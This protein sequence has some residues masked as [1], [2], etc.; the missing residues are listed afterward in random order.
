MTQ[1]MLAR[2]RPD[3]LN[4]KAYSSARSLYE[5]D[6]STIFLDANECAFEP[7]IGAQNLSRYPA[8]QPIK[9]MN[10]LCR[11]YDVSSRNLIST[12]GADEAI[13]T[14]IRSICIP[15]ID[16]III[17]P[18]T[19][20]MYEH[21]AT[22]Q[23]IEV[24]KAPLNDDFSI[25]YNAIKNMATGTT[26]IVFLCSPNNPTGSYIPIEQIIELCNAFENKTFIV[27]DETYIEF[28]G[29]E[30]AIRLTEKYNNLIIMRT[31]SKA[32]AAAGIRCGVAISQSYIIDVLKKVIAPYPISQCV[33]NEVTTILSEKNLKRLNT[34]RRDI[35]RIRD[36][37]INQIQKLPVVKK[38][39]PTYANF[40]LVEFD[41]ADKICNLCKNNGIIL[42]NQSHQEKLQN[43][44]RIGIGSESDMNKL[45]QILSGRTISKTIASRRATI[46]RRTNETSI[47][48]TVDLDSTAPIFINTGIG[49]YDHMLEQIA[50]HAGFSL[51]LECDGDLHIDPHHTIEDCAIAFGQCLKEALGNKLG[52]GRYG[53]V[54]PMDESEASCSLDLSNRSYL[55][56]EGNF[57]ATMVGDLPTDMIEH[58]FRSIA[59]NLGASIHLKVYGDNAHHMVE[60]CFKSFA[61]ALGQ[62][63][64]ISSTSLPSSKG[65]L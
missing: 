60:A 63:I 35:I 38:I 36:Q 31:L 10:A 29:L 17:C 61:R 55:K 25:N 33:A 18:P 11:L 24:K 49:F 28:S 45:V 13:D 39:Y 20:P 50:K 41:D 48:V 42:R 56:F 15:S 12:R 16:N 43:C 64:K 65:I 51:S 8:Q 53:F 14:L 54:V 7:Y 47:A 6:E 3:I 30:S 22:L 2:F 26:K 23:N 34:K 46:N 58:I 59:E 4:M 32:Y 37:S 9:M 19:F 52:I 62:A 27:V 40:I 57:P 5:G 21:S 44:V 1:F